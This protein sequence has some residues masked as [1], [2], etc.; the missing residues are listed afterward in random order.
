MLVNKRI[1]ETAT[2]AD[3][4]KML[5]NSISEVGKYELLTTNQYLQQMKIILAIIEDLTKVN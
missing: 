2:I 3:K 1:P 5:T 4:V